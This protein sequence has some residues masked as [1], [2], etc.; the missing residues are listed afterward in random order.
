MP[1]K[2]KKQETIMDM[3]E[4]KTEYFSEQEKFFSYIV[5]QIFW[6]IRIR[7]WNGLMLRMLRT[8][9]S[10]CYILVLQQTINKKCEKKEKG[11]VAPSDDKICFSKIC[12]SNRLVWHRQLCR[13]QRLIIKVIPDNSCIKMIP[14]IASTFA[15]CIAPEQFVVCLR[16]DYFSV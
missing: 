14:T 15:V 6:G 16:V 8:C 12:F 5:C 1:K 13:Y 3:P 7:R 10:R 9:L 11:R 2:E 4:N